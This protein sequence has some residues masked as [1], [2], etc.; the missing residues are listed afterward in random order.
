M[1]LILCIFL[2]LC[3]PCICCYY[4]LFYFCYGESGWE[5]DRTRVSIWFY[6][7]SDETAV[8]AV[9]AY[10][11]AFGYIL[12]DVSDRFLWISL[13]YVLRVMWRI[14][15]ITSHIFLMTLIWAAIGGTA[16]TVKV[17][18]EALAF[19]I[20]CWRTQ[21]W[22]LLFG[23]VAL[24]V[25][26]TTD[27]LRNIS[28]RVG[29]YRTTTNIMFM[30]LIT[31]W[32]HVDFE[33]PRCPS[34]ESRE[35]LFS[36]LSMKII[37]I[38]TWCGVIMSPVCF[39]L[40]VIKKAFQNEASNS[41]DLEKMVKTK[42][43]DG[44]LEMQLYAG[45]YYVYDGGFDEGNKTNLLMLAMQQHKSA[46]ISHLME[47]YDADKYNETDGKE[48]NILDYYVTSVEESQARI[49]MTRNL[50][51]IYAKYPKLRSAEEEF[52]IFLCACYQ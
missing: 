13:L 47:I 17:G 25:S 35:R 31:V 18:I 19:C 32:F 42:N 14:L 5:R 44:I 46:V 33:C 6:Y 26:T 51:K 29:V 28:M 9:K 1:A 16:L 23:V 4:Y 15:D 22:E 10:V 43:Y 40:L 48:R 49:R 38:Y 52:S 34:Y 30:I 39:L 12:S 7:C 21:Q 20:L 36:R 24:V 8:K 2:S 37:F 11:G 3:S 41:R 27:E 50:M 45:R